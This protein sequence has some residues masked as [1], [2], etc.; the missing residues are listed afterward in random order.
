MLSNRATQALY[1]CIKAPTEAQ[2]LM[3]PTATLCEN[4]PQLLFRHSSGH[5]LVSAEKNH[6]NQFDA[7]VEIIIG[8]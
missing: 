3:N 7:G 5:N 6:P 4:C 1:S 8:S 2:N